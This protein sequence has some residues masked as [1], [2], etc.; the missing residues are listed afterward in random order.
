MSEYLWLV[1][2]SGAIHWINQLTCEVWTCECDALA[3]VFPQPILVDWTRIGLGL[4]G[5]GT[6][7]VTYL[8]SSESSRHLLPVGEPPSPS[9]LPANGRGAEKPAEAEVAD[10]DGPDV[11]EEQV[12]TL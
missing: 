9:P 6:Q 8:E 12:G 7:N 1:R 11:V 10:L 4:D 3:I 2:T 5:Q